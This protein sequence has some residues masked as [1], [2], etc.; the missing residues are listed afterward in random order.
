M[1]TLESLELELIGAI[2]EDPHG[3]ILKCIGIQCDKKDG[4]RVLAINQNG[5]ILTPLLQSSLTKIQKV[6]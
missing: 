6:N 5:K 1:T 4:Y 3:N 2:L